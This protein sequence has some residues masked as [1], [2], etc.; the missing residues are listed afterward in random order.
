MCH[1]YVIRNNLTYCLLIDLLF[2][3]LNSFKKCCEFEKGVN[4]EDACK[5][6]VHK[7]HLIDYMMTNT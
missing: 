6:E 3:C 1:I 5:D 2:F 4:T 7:T